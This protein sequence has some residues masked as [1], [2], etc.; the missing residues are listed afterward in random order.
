MYFGG[1]SPAKSP[2]T[3]GERESR[4]RGEREG[5]RKKK[6]KKK[7]ACNTRA[8]KKTRFGYTWVWPRIFDI[9]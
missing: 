2:V 1:R 5:Q 9:I 4:E 6:E 3:V 8:K 7:G